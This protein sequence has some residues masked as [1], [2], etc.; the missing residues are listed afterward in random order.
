[1]KLFNIIC[2]TYAVRVVN[3]ETKFCLERTTATG[4]DS[5]SEV[6]QEMR[7]R[8]NNYFNPMP[9]GR[10]WDIKTARPFC[11]DSYSHLIFDMPVPAGAEDIVRER[12]EFYITK[13]II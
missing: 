8:Y 1:M 13:A 7:N 4:C 12:R 5:L 9:S 3:G 2:N 10:L 11:G 6:K